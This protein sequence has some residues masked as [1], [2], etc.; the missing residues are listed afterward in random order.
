MATISISNYTDNQQQSLSEVENKNLKNSKQQ[1]RQKVHCKKQKNQQQSLSAC[2]QSMSATTVTISNN[3]H[4][5]NLC[6]QPQ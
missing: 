2:Q 3:P 4:V 5:N 6:Q 1:N